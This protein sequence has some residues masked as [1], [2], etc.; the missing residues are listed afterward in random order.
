M[1]NPVI[2]SAVAAASFGY[3]FAIINNLI[4]SGGWEILYQGLLISLFY[5]IITA[6][7]S[8]VLLVFLKPAMA[9]T[10]NIISFVIFICVGFSIPFYLSYQISWLSN[11][12][13]DPFVG[14][15]RVHM[16]FSLFTVGGI[17]MVSSLTAWLTIWR[18][19]DSDST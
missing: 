17:G 9:H 15:Q 16:L 1:T 13:Q 14:G 6:F 2:N 3:V 19:S 11:H 5:F 12:G 8:N 4:F 18:N 10:S 7:F